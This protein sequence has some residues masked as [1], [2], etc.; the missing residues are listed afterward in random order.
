MALRQKKEALLD[1]VIPRRGEKPILLQ[2]RSSKAF[3]I[4]I[5]CWS[6]FTVRSLR[7]VEC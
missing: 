7:A 4:F 5:V 1:K 6:V 2:Y 3:I